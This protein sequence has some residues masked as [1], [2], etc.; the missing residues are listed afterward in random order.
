VSAPAVDGTSAG[1]GARG[2]EALVARHEHD[3]LRITRA[4]LRDEHLGADAAQEAFVRLWRRMGE[5][6]AALER[7]DAWLRRA[8]LSAALD[9]VRR[10]E[11]RARDV[12]REAHALEASPA[13][14]PSPLTGASEAELRARLDQALARLPEGQRTV[15]VLRHDGGLALREV[16]DLL[17]VSLPTVKTQFAR[18]CLRL[19]AHLSAF[20]DD[21]RT[22]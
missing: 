8:A 18:A 19:Q 20:R 6:G 17:G 16:A 1:S 4:V 13:A 21:V 3:V 2:F 12:Q 11:V 7:P 14:G 9:L 22:P 15:F 10:R 5:R